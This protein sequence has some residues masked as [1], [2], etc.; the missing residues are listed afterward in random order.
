MHF[1]CQAFCI[2]KAQSVKAIQAGA[3]PRVVKILLGKHTYGHEVQTES[4]ILL[5]IFRIQAAQPAQMVQ[6]ELKK[7]TI[8]R[9]GA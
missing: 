9:K 4:F 7:N 1:H 8:K 5:S 2:Q 6:K 3:G